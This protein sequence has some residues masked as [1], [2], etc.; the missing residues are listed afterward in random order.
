MTSCLWA[1]SDLPSLCR[2][3]VSTALKFCFITFKAM[4]NQMSVFVACRQFDAVGAAKRMSSTYCTKVCQGSTSVMKICFRIPFQN[5]CWEA[6]A[7]MEPGVLIFVA[8]VSKCK[9]WP[10]IFWH[11]N[12]KESISQINNSDD[13]VVLELLWYL[14][15]VGHEPFCKIYHL[16]WELVLMGCHGERQIS[17][18]FVFCL[19]CL[20][21]LLV[22]YDIGV[23]H[24]HTVQ[25]KRGCWNVTKSDIIW[26]VGP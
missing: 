2:H 15:L 21:W 7:L 22:L 10:Q 14:F 8:S 12:T 16:L 17:K 13:Q 26:T 23:W 20:P 25:L 18:G 5:P 6:E 11:G 9:S 19:Q 1:V 4:Y 3:N 24:L